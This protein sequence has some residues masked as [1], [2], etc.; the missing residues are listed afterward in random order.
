MKAS[1][2]IYIFCI[3]SQ[4]AS[5]HDFS[6][7]NLHP[8]EIG[9]SVVLSKLP[10][11]DFPKAYERLLHRGLDQKSSTTIGTNGLL[12]RNP[13][14]ILLTKRMMSRPQIQKEIAEMNEGAL[15]YRIAAT[16]GEFTNRGPHGAEGDPP[17]SCH[18]GRIADRAMDKAVDV[19]MNEILV[20]EARVRSVVKQLNEERRFLD[21]N[22]YQDGKDS[23]PSAT[24]YT[25][26]FRSC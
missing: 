2:M 18:L 21:A 8:R 11:R 20:R 12:R 24:Q 1:I 25:N 13:V 16:C 17:L 7:T 5:A 22:R 9:N 6:W 15:Q 3:T 10:A 23:I 14:S 4:V 26:D 19:H